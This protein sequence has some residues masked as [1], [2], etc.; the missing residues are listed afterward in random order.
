MPERDF[1]ATIV[2]PRRFWIAVAI[3]A[4]G[5]LGAAWAALPPATPDPKI[6]DC[7]ILRQFIDGYVETFPAL[8]APDL[9]GIETSEGREEV[10]GAVEQYALRINAIRNTSLAV[11]QPMRRALEAQEAVEGLCAGYRK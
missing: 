7:Q 11:A 5:L 3:V 8:R 1:M 6:A 10:Q 9:S 2:T 4:L